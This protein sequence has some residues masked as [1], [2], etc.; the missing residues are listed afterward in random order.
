[1][2]LRAPFA[3]VTAA[4]M[5]SAI[6]MAAPS[7]ISIP[8]ESVFPESITVTAKNELLIA[9]VGTGAVYRAAP[10]ASVARLWL[11]PARTGMRAAFG[12]LADER[13]KTLFLCSISPRG[14]P[15]QPELAR[16]RAF[17][18]R[19][20]APKGSYALPSP[21]T[22]IC[23]D[24]AVDK[25]GA[26]YV[27]DTGNASVLRLRPKASELEVWVKDE[28]LNTVDGLAFGASGN[29]YVNAVRTNRL[30]RIAKGAGGAAGAITELAPSLPLKGPDGMR[31]LDGERFLMAENSPTDGRITVVTVEGDRARM[32]VLLQ[33]PTVTSMARIGDKLWIVDAQ[34][35]HWPGNPEA[36][37]PAGPF[38]AFSIDFP[39]LR[40]PK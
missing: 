13:S 12:I 4:A 39:R 1:M 33:H 5:S 37:K 15:A 26:A 34:S 3:G 35:P 28:R 36:D 40:S 8:G 7:Q 16:L 2:V 29:L 17:D 11:D 9:S 10:G 31:P 6:C 30:F 25:D 22:A 18:L 20:G 38:N 23:N 14:A 24:I 21:A 19:T 27:T 32:E